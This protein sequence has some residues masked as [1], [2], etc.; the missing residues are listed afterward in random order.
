VARIRHV[1]RARGGRQYHRSAHR[2]DVA[3]L[4]VLLLGVCQGRAPALAIGDDERS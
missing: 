1:S 2:I 4:V 3:L